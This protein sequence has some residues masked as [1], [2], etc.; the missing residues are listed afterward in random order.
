MDW[1]GYITPIARDCR[2]VWPRWTRHILLV[3][4]GM[5]IHS[6]EGASGTT[7][8]VGLCSTTPPTRHTH[9]LSHSQHSHQ[10]DIAY[11]VLQCHKTKPNQT[12]LPISS[13][14][15]HYM[16]QRFLCSQKWN[17]SWIRQKCKMSMS[18][19]MTLPKVDDFYNGGLRGNSM[20]F[21]WSNWNFVPG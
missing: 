12:K 16:C 14:N 21:V 5:R 4:W 3:G 2:M 17:I 18:I 8:L 19:D 13:W 11:I 9:S 6:L 7:P 20:S 10:R 1:G 15:L